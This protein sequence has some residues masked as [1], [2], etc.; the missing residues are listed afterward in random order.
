MHFH[1][2]GIAG[3]GMSALAE[4][5]LDVGATVSGSDRL[6]DS[7]RETPV[8]RRLRA[9][10]IRIVPQNGSGLGRDTAA[11]VVSTAIES[12]NADIARARA[13][14]I[15]VRHRSDVLAE[16]IG[17]R[18]LI[19]VAGTCGKSTTTAILGTIL[20]GC[21]ADPAVVNGAGVVAWR[22]DSRTGAVRKGRGPC[23]AE[24]DESDRSLLRFHPAHA[25]VTNASADHFPLEETLALFARF[26]AQVGGTVVD[27]TAP[28]PAPPA[29]ERVPWGCRFAWEGVE[30][31]VPVPG[32]HNEMNAWQAVRMA[33]AL[34]YPPD[35]IARA[36]AGFRGVDRRLELV[37]RTPCGA[38]VVDDYAHNTEKIRAAW[39]ALRAEAE[40]GRVV[41]LWRPHGYGPLR[42]MLGDLAAMFAETLG[43]R[44][45]LFLLPVYDAG[46][47]ADRSIRTDDLLA[48][49]RE[50]GIA[51]AEL[52]A[53]HDEAVAAMSATAEPG[54]VLLTLGARDPELPVTAKRLASSAG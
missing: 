35:D 54:D 20:E 25:I 5:L 51:G 3:V 1:L 53:D 11:L 46:G 26:R 7:G 38:V 19:A 36:L 31:A 45:R 14:G 2:T 8:V 32:L 29:F 43:P 48:A 41:G 49:L 10:G 40:S 17:D 30:Y 47:T 23:V 18:P 15:P 33:L 9:Q 4:A 34:G 24:V 6:V 44:D 50:R 42:H 21:G 12:D 22:S 27:G 52:A 13:L 37:G 16:V 39:L 28:D